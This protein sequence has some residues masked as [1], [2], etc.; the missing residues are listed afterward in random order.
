[1][2]LAWDDPNLHLNVVYVTSVT[3]VT[4]M[5]EIQNSC[6]LHQVL[7]WAKQHQQRLASALAG[8]IAKQEL[9]EALLAWLQW[10][11]TTLSDRDKEV[12]PQEIEEVKALIAEHQVNR[13]HPNL[14][15]QTLSLLHTVLLR[16]LLCAS[17][18]HFLRH[19]P[20]LLHR[21]SDATAALELLSGESLSFAG[22]SCPV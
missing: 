12:I 6:F 9:L 1:M 15:S 4:E 14:P 18:L 10:A 2:G 16:R 5:E 7:A 11:E 17:Y 21:V 20:Q 13:C 8:L 22:V 19:T 3:S